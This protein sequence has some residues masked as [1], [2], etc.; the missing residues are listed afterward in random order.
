MVH[1]GASTC[2]GDLLDDGLR[3]GAS[4]LRAVE[5]RAEVVHDDRCPLGRTRQRM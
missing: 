1:T 2:A 5:G 4:G 3:L